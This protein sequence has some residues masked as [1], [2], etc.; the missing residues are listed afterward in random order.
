MFGGL[1]AFLGI[2]AGSAAKAAYDNYDMKKTTR[3]VDEKGN[4][5]YADRLCNEYI[6][7]ERV[8]KVKTTDRNGVKL[9]STVGVNSNRVYNTSYGRGTQQ[10]F[11]MSEYEKQD[12]IERGKL[13]Y[14]QYNPYFGRSVTTEISTG[15]TITCLFKGKDAETGKMVYKKW[16]FRPECQDKYDWRN[17]AKGDYG[18]DITE[19]E[20][21]KLKIVGD[22]SNHLP[23]DGQ[24]LNKL[25]GCTCFH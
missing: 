15:R 11:A 19:N 2:Y 22:T 12:A 9:Y 23:S 16:Y 25:W 1:L 14:M 10:L 7:G 5:H 17:T 18:I 13:A 24:V 21:E 6:N 20:Y 3:T 4:V 8:K